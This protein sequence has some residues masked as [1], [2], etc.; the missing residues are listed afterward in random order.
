M[1]ASDHGEMSSEASEASLAN[2]SHQSPSVEVIAS[3]VP[4][5]STI[6]TGADILSIC[7]LVRFDKVR[8]KSQLEHFNTFI[9][10]QVRT[11]DISRN[12]ILQQ[13]AQSTLCRVGYTSTTS[14]DQR[15]NYCVGHTVCCLAA[16]HMDAQ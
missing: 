8:A 4:T 6:L 10:K 5:R 2:D 3:S 13:M 16:M 9:A 11:Q 15:K 14:S 1:A 7:E 12:I